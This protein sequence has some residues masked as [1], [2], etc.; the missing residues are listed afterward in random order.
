MKRNIKN[1]M[2]TAE[3]LAVL[4]ILIG[5]IMAIIGIVF[6]FNR[7]ILQLVPRMDIAWMGFLVVAS[8]FLVSGISLFI[9]SIKEREWIN[10][11][12]ER[13]ISIMA[14]SSRKFL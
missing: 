5:I 6:F 13:E 7:D 11:T 8:L 4:I 1:E 10:E 14:P 3:K 9:S 2:K 12:D